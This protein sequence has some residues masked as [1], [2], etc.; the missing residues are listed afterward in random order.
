MKTL[1]STY[2][3]VE[4]I[5][6]TLTLPFVS[7]TQSLVP[8]GLVLCILLV[9]AVVRQVHKLIV[10]ILHGRRIPE[11][12]TNCTELGKVQNYRNKHLGDKYYKCY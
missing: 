4:F 11:K 6:M 3:E 7:L 8:V 1:L 2:Q 12:Y 5:I 9:H 10:D